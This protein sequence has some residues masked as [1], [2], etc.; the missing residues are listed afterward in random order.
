[1]ECGVRSSGLTRG[2]T[3]FCLAVLRVALRTVGFCAAGIGV[4]LDMYVIVRILICTIDSNYKWVV[5]VRCGSCPWP[6]SSSFFYA[7]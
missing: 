6:R 7:C 5:G 2:M 4:G 3:Y 1:M